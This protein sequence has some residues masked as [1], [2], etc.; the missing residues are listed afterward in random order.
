MYDVIQKS[1]KYKNS[2]LTILS[3]LLFFFYYYYKRFMIYDE[4][5]S[6]NGSPHIYVLHND[7]GCDDLLEPSISYILYY[8]NR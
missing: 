7:G 3:Y 2:F 4:W 8:D 5:H 6:I 1:K